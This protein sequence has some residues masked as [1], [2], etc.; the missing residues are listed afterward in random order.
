MTSD[1]AHTDMNGNPTTQSTVAF[2]ASADL[3]SIAYDPATGKATVPVENIQAA[4]AP[5]PSAS[6]VYDPSGEWTIA[7]VPYDLPKGYSALCAQNSQ[8]CNGP[9]A[10][11]LISLK[12]YRGVLS[13]DETTPVFGLQIWQGGEASRL[14]CGTNI[15]MTHAEAL[16]VG[17]DFSSTG[18][19]GSFTYASSVTING[20][21]HAL[22][23]DYQIAGASS[24][25][26]FQLGC[27]SQTI[28]VGGV[29]QL[30]WVCTGKAVD[31]TTSLYQASAGGGC[32]SA[33]TN[34][35]VEI[36]GSWTVDSGPNACSS[37]DLG[38]GFSLQTCHGTYNS[39]AIVCTNEFGVFSNS[40][41]SSGSAVVYSS[42]N[43]A[44]QFDWSS[45][46][47]IA[48]G[49]A[50]DDSSFSG[51]DLQQAQCYVQYF[52]QNVDEHGSA[53]LKRI[54]TDW[55]AST[56]ANFIRK[57]NNPRSL[58]AFNEFHPDPSGKGGA[59]RMEQTQIQGI[60]SASCHGYTP[61]NTFEV[62]EFS[63][64]KLDSKTLLAT[65]QSTTIATDTSKPDCVAHFGSA[66]N[67]SVQKFVFYL[68]K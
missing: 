3:G 28:T 53:C 2:T 18:A 36:N 61:C 67:G 16:A 26:S 48:Q 41:L 13:S 9:P 38:G 19:E 63:Y 23:N 45:L 20:T 62:D 60:Q 49:T 65:Y 68:K 39:Q 50:C 8:N 57:G 51:H 17:V 31:G 55:S 47:Q 12:Q 43:T 14:A 40:S 32:V 56:V 34:K 59:M 44:T 4:V 66:G 27:G 15:G 54:D 37:V 1:A 24:Q 30:G 42:S 22:T 33:A 21:S 7:A 6:E 58:V 5:T 52:Q 29:S 11:Q 10:G 25:Y 35:P 46:T 64:K